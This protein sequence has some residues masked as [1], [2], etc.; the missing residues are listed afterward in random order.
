MRTAI[1]LALILATPPAV[2]DDRPANRL[3]KETSPYLLQHAHNPVD[4][5]PWGPEA[6]AKAKA[7][8]KPLFLSVGY[9]ACYWCHV[10]ERESFEDAGVAKV[11]NEH[12]VCVKVDREERPD[13]D[14]VYMTA[15]QAYTGGGGWPMSVFLFPDGRPFFAGTYFPKEGREGSPGFVAILDAIRNAWT[16]Q[17]PALERDGD[18]LAAIVR[19]Q[20]AADAGRRA[21]LSRALVTAGR[22][23][24]AEQYDPDYAGFGYDPDQ[25]RRPKFPEPVNLVFLLDQHRRGA[26]ASA[27]EGPSPLDMAMATLDRLQRGGI[28]DHLAGGYHRYSVNRDW[29]VPHFEK[30][31]YDNAQL[32]S[33]QLQ[34]FELTGDARWRREAEATLAFVARDLTDP[35]T[36]AFYSALDAESQAEEGQ[37]YVWSRAEIDAILGED[38]ALFAQAYGLDGPP[39]FEGERFVLREPTPR[40]ELAKA[41]GLDPEALEARLVPLRTKLLA[42]RDRRPQ[43]RLDDK[44]LTSWNGLMIAAYADAYRLTKDDRHRIAAEKAADFLLDRLRTP[45]GRLLRTYRAGT[46]KL[47]AY[48]EDY[49]YLSWGL[50]RL[51]A[52]TGDRSR[53]DQARALADRMIADFADDENGAF[54]ATAD[55][56]EALLARFKDPFDG[57][58]PGANAVAVRVLLALAAAADDPTY[59]DRAQAA[60]EGL[61]APLSR[62]PASAPLLLVALDEYYDARPPAVLRPGAFAGRVPPP[63]PP[64]ARPTSSPSPPPRPTPTPRLPPAPRWPSGSP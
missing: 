1:A 49:A 25:P 43:P 64:P 29:S 45:E 50:L 55:D 21:P 26:D 10:M 16:D 8:G 53:L 33:A 44:I 59:L 57:A 48:L 39:N 15:T 54:F 35:D 46:A 41:V 52:A 23:G 51:H 6:F 42:V 58:L 18:A 47:P 13:V 20:A 56:H 60:L 22:S 37:S 5:Y 12:F 40:D 19:R 31:L 32:A 7:E 61:S 3:A 30:M 24:L 2:D 36:G 62:S 63:P 28:R 14:Q 11:L 4:W 9:S 38:A 27:P 17:R 34:A